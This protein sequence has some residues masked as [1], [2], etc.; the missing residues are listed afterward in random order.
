MATLDNAIKSG[1]TIEIRLQAV[2]VAM[3]MTSGAFQTG[4]L[5]YFT[6]R[7][8][9]PSLM[10]LV[11]DV[12]T[13]N[14]AILPFLLTGLLANYNKFESHNQ[15]QTRF[16]D[17]ADSHAI[18]KV[19]RCVGQACESLRDR[20]T[21]IQNDL[22]EPWTVGGTLSY[23]GLGALAG[24]KP[25]M[26]SPNE[27]EAKALFTE[28]PGPQTASIL[29]VY[30]FAITNKLFCL[31]FIGKQ[32]DSKASVSGLASLLSFT[33][34]LLQHV[35]RSNRATIY[36]HL[37]LTVTQIFA[38]D[39]TIMKRLCETS[40][41]IRLCRQRPPF[42]PVIKGDRTF[43][44]IMLD[45]MVDSINH[46]LRKKLDV[47]LYLLN[48]GIM[49]RI[50]SYLS[51]N[52]T[53]IAY[54]WSELWRSLLSFVRFLI[55]Y[56]EDLRGLP[57]IDTLVHRLVNLITLSL[58][59]GESFLPDSA[60][61]DDLFYKLVESGDS[62][63]S[64]RSAYSQDMAP[65]AD[66]IET[67]IGVSKHYHNLIVDAKGKGRKNLSP[68]E[69]AKIIKDGYNTLSIEAREGLDQWE[70]YREVDHKAELKRIA[71]IVVADAKIICM[72][73]TNE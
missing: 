56:V 1:R 38:E 63:I 2:R 4:L 71:R 65:C 61:Y 33:S 49:I 52:R 36:A 45:I 7:E 34:Y 30:E 12:E 51:M 40:K 3:S 41:T 5:T 9:F 66:A 73:T 21:S 48:I 13:P 47:P 55:V 24:A 26:V 27:D 62:L 67:L 46:N 17:F 32:D 44:A 19:I 8:L 16:A 11:Q 64:F 29:S 54:H 53:R 57:G 70:R 35:H 10:Q 28:Q 22:P 20:Y 60:S 37:V 58:T 14:D 72:T 31:E 25:A 39:A 68:R 6:Q 23:V 15:H 18:T 42:L 59:T 69:V 43:V 50:I